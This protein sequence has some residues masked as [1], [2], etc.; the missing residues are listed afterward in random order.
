MTFTPIGTVTLIDLTPETLN[1]GDTVEHVQK[2]NSMFNKLQSRLNE[3][4]A[5]INSINT[6]GTEVTDALTNANNQIA[7]INTQAT[8][9]QAQINAYNA[10]NGISGT[11]LVQLGNDIDSL[12]AASG[13]VVADTGNQSIAGEKTF[14]SVAKFNDG[15]DINVASGASEAVNFYENGVLAARMFYSG[16]GS[17]VSFGKI[18]GDGTEGA[19]F[20]FYDDFATFKTELRAL[21][22]TTG[23]SNSLAYTTKDY[24]DSLNTPITTTLA[25]ANALGDTS[26][27][28]EQDGVE[29]SSI[30][31]NISNLTITHDKTDPA[32]TDTILRMDDDKATLNKPLQL[33]GDINGG[34]SLKIG[35]TNNIAKVS[36]KAADGMSADYTIELPQSLPSSTGDVLA[37]ASLTAAKATLQWQ[38]PTAGSSSTEW[39]N[40]AGTYTLFSDK[41]WVTGHFDNTSS[42]A[43][44]WTDGAGT[45][46]APVNADNWK[47]LGIPLRAGDIIKSL[48]FR[49]RGN[50]NNI[51]E[52]EY[53]G[54]FV[55]PTDQNQ[56]H[57]GIFG[58]GEVTE[59]QAFNDVLFAPSGQTAF[60]TTS[61][62]KM[63]RTIPIN[64]TAPQEGTLVF[65]VKPTG[66]YGGNV[67][68][69]ANLLWEIERAGT[70]SY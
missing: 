60:T 7:I 12:V 9:L 34:S 11:D 54:V 40:E 42:N 59:V 45:G 19:T 38:T 61:G 8:N 28:F 30:V 31:A 17:S 48:E 43:V 49:F 39:R 15:I 63:K 70:A 37:V 58:A 4:S 5:S 35:S 3:I 41:R 44:N 2:M 24:V 14:T 64:Y 10:I 32:K 23:S 25:L 16:A 20:D 62:H 21:A 68:G 56:W 6:V 13:G 27:T 50:D 52:I 47:A 66:T 57:V 65:Y 1:I 69:Y 26:V 55:Y 29:V 53:Y 33:L 36:V 51:D 67:S 46:A 22:S 18:K